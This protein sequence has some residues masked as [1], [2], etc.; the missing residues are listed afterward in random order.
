M[1][2]IKFLNLLL[3]LILLTSC[4]VS[5]KSNNTNNGKLKNSMEVVINTNPNDT[6]S[7]SS[8]FPYYSDEEKKYLDTPYV[9]YKLTGPNETEQIRILIEVR[10]GADDIVETDFYKQKDYIISV[11]S[12]KWETFQIPDASNF[13]YR[14]ITMYLGET[15][16]IL[17]STTIHTPYH[18]KNATDGEVEHI[19]PDF[20]PYSE[21]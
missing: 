9:H 12:G 6:E 1:K 11:E 19:D 3:V 5:N 8:C 18:S 2:R 10:W 21:Q 4:G 15:D 16:E 7:N 20:K 17:Y 13:Y 14:R